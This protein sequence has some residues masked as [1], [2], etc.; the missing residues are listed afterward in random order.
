[1]AD[2]ERILVFLK[3]PHPGTV[4]TRLAAAIGSERACSVYRQMAE[5][6]VAEAN[7]FGCGVEIHY[8]PGS[9][10]TEMRN[11]LGPK[12]DYFAQ[13]NGDLG[14]RMIHA[15]TNA[16]LRGAQRVALVGGD[17]PALNSDRLTMAFERLR[18]QAEIKPAD[19]V[20]GPA[21][22]GGFY[23]IAV[24]R[25]LPT[26][27]IGVPWSS[28][29]TR[30]ASEIQAAK[31]GLRISELPTEDDVD[32]FVGWTKALNSGFLSGP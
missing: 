32:D 24:S 18:P 14:E 2:G 12:P 21:R 27:F 11:W 17:C 20:F 6:Q 5:K 28:P 16:F 19:V 29:F 31:A 13:A 22:D 15:M 30:I 10:E 4:K 25:P 8:S 1:M 3:A 26:L 23:L 9:A 7:R